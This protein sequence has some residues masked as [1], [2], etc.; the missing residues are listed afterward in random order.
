[1][2]PHVNY[3]LGKGTK[4]NQKYNNPNLVANA[5]IVAK[6]SGQNY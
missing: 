3:T 4:R 5:N 6:R 2:K 1:M